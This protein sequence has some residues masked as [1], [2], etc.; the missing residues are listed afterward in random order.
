MEEKFYSYKDLAEKMAAEMK[1][2]GTTGGD[3]S[4]IFFTAVANMA[5]ILMGMMRMMQGS[6]EIQS[7][8]E[9]VRE[10]AR[11]CDFVNLNIWNKFF[12]IRN[13]LAHYQV[14]N[15]PVD[16]VMQVILPEF[17]KEFE[18]LKGME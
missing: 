1:E 15:M 4:M 13:Q 3:R 9:I 2:N 12:E 8:R 16:M 7:P 5:Q 14:D 10:Q 6:K 18:V 11:K 17:V